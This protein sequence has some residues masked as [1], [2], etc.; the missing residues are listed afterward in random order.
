MARA[1]WLGL[2]AALM[3]PACADDRPAEDTAPETEQK[4][5]GSLTLNLTGADTDGRAYR[6]RHADFAIS[7]NGYYGDG[8]GDGDYGGDGDY[9]SSTKIVSS[10]TDPDAATITERLVPGYYGVSLI[11]E[12]WYLERLEEG[13]WS[14]VEQAV[15]LSERYQYAYIYNQST[16][17]VAY[18]FGVDG[19]L[20]DFRS[21]ELQIGIEIEQ[22][23]EGP[24]QPEC[25]WWPFPGFPCPGM[26]DAGVSVD[27]G[28]APEADAGTSEFPT[29]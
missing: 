9:E 6:L 5:L 21:G 1:T 22:P 14:R 2:A 15:L 10:E 24:A 18:R 12:D 19:E 17:L 23:G 27:G 16:S 29:P 26:G 7:S 4:E 13:G 3:L 28:S 25:P 20:I 8:D 11:S